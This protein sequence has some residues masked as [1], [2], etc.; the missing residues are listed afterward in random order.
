M[1]MVSTGYPKFIKG[2]QAQELFADIADTDIDSYPDQ[3]YLK[4]WI[5]ACYGV[6][7]YKDDQ[8]NPELLDKY[9]LTSMEVRRQGA[10][11]LLVSLITGQATE[12]S[13][14]PIK[15]PAHEIVIAFPQRTFFEKTVQEFADGDYSYGLSACFQ[16]FHKSRPEL[17][18]T[19]T[20]FIDLWGNT[21]KKFTDYDSF[22]RGVE[23]LK[24]R[25][26][27]V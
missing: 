13:C 12:V 17:A 7:Q 16:V 20:P 3:S 21:K 24:S 27:L 23:N 11:G 1:R 4:S 5:G 18:A 25:V 9:K 14:L 2:Q 8:V 6:Y 10:F 15:L 26:N 22:I 19:K